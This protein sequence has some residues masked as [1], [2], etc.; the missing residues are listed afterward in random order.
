MNFF[1]GTI[2]TSR[3]PCISVPIL[4]IIRMYNIMFIHILYF[5]LCIVSSTQPVISFCYYFCWI[6]TISPHYGKQINAC[7]IILWCLNNYCSPRTLQITG[8]RRPSEASCVTSR[9]TR[10][11]HYI[12]IYKRTWF[13]KTII[14]HYVC[15]IPHCVEGFSFLVS[16]ET[17]R[18]NVINENERVCVKHYNIIAVR[19]N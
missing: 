3:K 9:S 13:V 4:S 6:T 8:E 16:I 2:C 15:V 5:I 7:N 11:S 14:I 12:L 18:N 1:V 17:F 10:G 19:N